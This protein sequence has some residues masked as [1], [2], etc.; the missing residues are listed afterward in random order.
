MLLAGALLAAQ[1]VL[2]VQ[3]AEPT[4]KLFGTAVGGYSPK[5]DVLGTVQK[6]LGP[7]AS[8]ADWDEI[9]KQY[10]Q[11][12]TDLKAFCEK[13]R[14]APN[15]FAC[16]TVGGKRFWQ[17]QRQYF[18][19]R[20]DHKL[21]DDFLLHDQL[22][23]NFLLLGSW[24]DPRPV[25]VKI[26]DYNASDAAKFA[27]SEEITATRKQAAPARMKEMAGVY[28]LVTINGQKVPTS[29]NHDGSA[30]QIRSGSFTIAPD[31]KC[32]SRM[33]FVP[34]SRPEMTL[35]RAA[36]YTLA[37]QHMNQL[38]MRWDGAGTTTGTVEGNTFTMQNEGMALVYRK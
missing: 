9:K 34:P 14:L 2:S 15:G 22:Q 3:A 10:G 23:N 6:E 13:V 35:D 28:T 21:P 11:S 16:V 4:Y 27:K 5:D 12:E 7:R 8:V 25:L 31:G 26:T 37:G 20:A 33:C 19:F 17:E 1:A 29:I 38:N 32:S 18:V 30:L 24:T 36:T